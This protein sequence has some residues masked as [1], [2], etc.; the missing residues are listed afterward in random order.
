MSVAEEV[1]ALRDSSY[2]NEATITLLEKFVSE[3]STNAAV[4]SAK[5]NRGLLK[6]YQMFPARLNQDVVTTIL[7]KVR[8]IEPEYLFV[9]ISRARTPFPLP[10]SLQSLTALPEPDYLLASYLVPESL[11]SSEALTSLSELERKLQ[12]GQFGS[13]WTSAKEDSAR[14]LLGRVAG[15]DDAVRLFIA[16]AIERTYQRIDL[17]S[18]AAA[19]DVVR[20]DDVSNLEPC[21]FIAS[22]FCAAV[23]QADAAAFSRAQGWTVDGGEAALPLSADNTQRPKQSVGQDGVKY[24]EIAGLINTLSR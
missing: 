11:R 14:A 8:A 9:I 18:L 21:R 23:V 15:V 1:V 3:E 2:F 7:V 4:Y 20:V 24:S 10:S 17:G 5:A 12:V 6:L 13:F 16:R 22:P 19:V